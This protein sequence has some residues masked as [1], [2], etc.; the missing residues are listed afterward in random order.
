MRWCKTSQHCMGAAKLTC[1]PTVLSVL[2][3]SHWHGLTSWLGAWFQPS[4]WHAGGRL[5]FWAVLLDFLVVSIVPACATLLCWGMGNT[6]SPN[7]RVIKAL[8]ALRG[9]EFPET[10][11]GKLCCARNWKGRWSKCCM[12][13]EII[14]FLVTADSCEIKHFIMPR[15]YLIGKSPEEFCRLAWNLGL[16]P[17]VVQL[18]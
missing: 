1:F 5:E 17:V 11:C 18:R 9:L 10:G 12:A 6:C 2:A 4:G 14:P 13:C 15:G 3:V 7:E 8:W 16:S